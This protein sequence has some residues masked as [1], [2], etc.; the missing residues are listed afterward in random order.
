MV[1]LRNNKI[2]L[3]ILSGFLTGIS[4]HFQSL[5][6]LAWFSLAP[7]FFVFIQI[8]SYKKIVKYSFLWGLTYNLISVYWIALNIGTNIYVGTLSM[9][10]TVLI[11]S[12]N[13][14][15]IGVVWFEIKKFLNVK[16]IYTLPLVWTYIEYIKSYG[17]LGFPW[18]SL[19]NTQTE[20]FYLIQNAEYVGIYG[21]SFW[22][23][24][25]NVFVYKLVNKPIRKYLF[26]FL[27]ALIFPFI[28]GFLILMNIELYENNEFKVSLIQP[29]I[30]LDDKWDPKFAKKN[31]DNLIAKT[32]ISIDEGSALIVWPESALPSQYGNNHSNINSL[33]NGNDVH[34][35]L[36]DVTREND[37]L[38]NSS[39]LLN[40]EGIKQ[41]Y[42]KKQL[43][44]MGEYVPFSN[45]IKVLQNINLGQGN[46]SSG[47]N[48]VIFTVNNNKFS[49]LICFEST[50]PDINRVHA[51]KG[52]D[53]FVYLVNDGWYT[54]IPEP[55][56]HAKQSI[57]RAIENR[58]SVLRCANTGLSMVISPLGEILKQTE[59]NTEDRIT[60]FISRTNTITFYTKYG[61]VFA[62]LMLIIT[63][64]LLF[65]SIYKNEK[66]N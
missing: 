61:N 40:K 18:I 47:V 51:K 56:Q 38:Y 31:F 2:F 50:F 63:M 13:T 23:V 12:L 62:Y 52:A 20:Y 16:A 4:Q 26:R 10:I 15:F 35:L 29:N 55:R 44:P 58:K 48:D 24:M 21:I 5:G 8:H 37:K 25:I 41:I 45:Y 3:I 1:Y 66:N 49:S 14:I 27:I 54:S 17:V 60:T 22:I 30:S 7:L 36:G 11:L 19:A 32:K 43:V 65:Y 28:S 46:F 42:N 39:V 33:F 6:F 59:L 57:Y 9:I 34:L 53:F 64:I